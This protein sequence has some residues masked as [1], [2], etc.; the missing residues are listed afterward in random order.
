MTDRDDNSERPLGR[1]LTPQTGKTVQ[2]MP[3]APPA[4]A[5]ASSQP[6]SPEDS[7]S[8]RPSPWDR[9][10]VTMDFSGP[11]LSLPAEASPDPSSRKRRS[12]SSDAWVLD[13]KRRSTPPV[14]IPAPVFEAPR[15]PADDVDPKEGLRNWTVP[16]TLAQEESGDALGLVDRAK[17]S[18]AHLDLE[19][20]MTERYALDDFTGA[21]R[22]AELLLGGDPEH[23]EATK[24]AESCRER[25]EQIYSSRV[26][27]LSRHVRVAVP[28]NEIRWLGL[29]H[30]AG[31]LLS[32]IDGGS[33][34]EEIIDMSGMARLEALKTLISLLDNGA[35]RIEEPGFG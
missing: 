30:R 27:A 33:T 23:A 4:D 10:R 19:E 21:L 13:R 7:E 3:L 26:G 28:E 16:P 14:G 11:P 15:P 9:G 8:S 20:E 1:V 6:G 12:E 32:R 25:L 35:I 31:F 17:P 2:G 18:H 5:T 22:T 29:D 34:I 24:Y